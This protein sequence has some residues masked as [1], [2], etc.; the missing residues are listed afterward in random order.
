MKTDEKNRKN[1]G[2]KISEWENNFAER[3]P[4][5]FYIVTE[6]IAELLIATALAVFAFHMLPPDMDVAVSR[7]STNS[8]VVTVTN[9]GFLFASGTFSIKSKNPVKKEPVTITGK[10][11]VD[12]IERRTPA[13]FGLQVSGLPYKKEVRIEVES[14]NITVDEE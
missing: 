3:H 14:G 7:K 2:T 5:C 6:F 8:S 10:K 11:Y 13:S 9:E 12:S 4:G 1:L